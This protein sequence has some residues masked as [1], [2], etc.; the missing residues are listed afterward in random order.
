M[1]KEEF[2]RKVENLI[3]ETG[4]TGSDRHRKCKLIVNL[5]GEITWKKSVK[6]LDFRDKRGWK[7]YHNEKDL[8]ISISLEA[9]L[10]PKPIMKKRA[11]YFK[12]FTKLKC[13]TVSGIMYSFILM[14]KKRTILIKIIRIINKFIT[15]RIKIINKDSPT[16]R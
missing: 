9:N 11:H 4:I 8:A 2:K 3:F 15:S 16:I 14:F 1:R 7:P 13:K 5:D 10:R 12:F 6:P